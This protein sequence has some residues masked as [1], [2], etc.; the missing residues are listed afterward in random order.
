MLVTPEFG[1]S[2]LFA[3]MLIGAICLQLCFLSFLLFFFY[4][5]LLF[6]SVTNETGHVV[7]VHNVA[8]IEVTDLTGSPCRE[9]IASPEVDNKLKWFIKCP[10]TLVN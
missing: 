2:F 5:F 7:S 10:L 8:R 4:Y 6:A 3:W 1:Q 9:V